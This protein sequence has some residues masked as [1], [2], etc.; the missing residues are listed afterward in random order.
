MKFALLIIGA[1]A[2]EFSAIL[3]GAFIQQTRGASGV[4]ALVLAMLGL[5]MAQ[6]SAKYKVKEGGDGR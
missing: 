4:V 1:M 6:A 5:L 2:C 3:L